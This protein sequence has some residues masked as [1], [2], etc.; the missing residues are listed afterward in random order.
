MKE[1]IV[2]LSLLL[3]GLFLLE[4]DAASLR[5]LSENPT[6]YDGQEVEI[7][8]EVLDELPQRDGSWF[9]LSDETASIGVWAKKGLRLPE[10]L[11]FGSYGVKGDI[12]RVQGT[13]QASCDNHLGQMGIHARQI[14]VIG[15]GLVRNEEV[16]RQKKELAFGWLVFF[17]ITFI[18]YLV[19]RLVKKSRKLQKR[20]ISHA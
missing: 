9:N 19:K 4:A 11:H 15:R 16:S 14:V 8:G 6:L 2:I 12:V 5:L 7:I 13:F 20:H 1:R 17:L 3:S 10:I 18:I